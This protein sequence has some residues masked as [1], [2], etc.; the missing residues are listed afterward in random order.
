MQQKS[1]E[2]T[3]AWR[4]ITAREPNIQ[5]RKD[6]DETAKLIYER[7]L[8]AFQAEVSAAQAELR[9]KL[10]AYK[11]FV[12]D[13]ESIRHQKDSYN[14]QLVAQAI[15]RLPNLTEV[16]LNFEHRGYPP[17]K[18][19]KRAYADS[20]F[21]PLEY[22]DH[23]LPDSVMQLWSILCGVVSAESQL[24]AL[25][26]DWMGL[27]LLQKF[28]EHDTEL[29]KRSVKDLETLHIVFK[30]D[31][32]TLGNTALSQEIADCE[33]FLRNYHMCDFISAARNLKIL[34][35]CLNEEFAFEIDLKYIVGTTTW[36]SLRVVD[37]DLFTTT[38]KTLIN[39]LHRHSET[40]KTLGLH[41]IMLTGASWVSVL[42]KIR[43]AVKLEDFRATRWW[44]TDNSSECW[45]I[46][47]S[48]DYKCDGITLLSA[49]KLG[50]AVK[51]YVLQGGTNP[52]LDWPL[53]S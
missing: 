44:G 45:G 10:E 27:N 6:Q 9:G 1:V 32:G 2:G 36:S 40:L 14:V 12:S 41:H 43:N 47:T 42:P 34:D 46:C 38:E 7:K 15:A 31:L 20:I 3:A 26:A 24:K 17:K 35:L 29:L 52:L 25:S 30:A 39:F 37:F 4:I 8:E 33:D 51:S 11:A 28:G 13:Q 23:G 49:C 53:G 50:L 16:T 19:F 48:P 21:Q 18:A 5:P 22:C